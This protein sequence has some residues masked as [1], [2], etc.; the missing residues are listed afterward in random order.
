MQLTRH[1]KIHG[2]VQDVYFRDFT[3]QQAKL[4]RLVGWVRNCRDG[5]VESIATGS[6]EAHQ[7]FILKLQQGPTRARVEW[8]DT[9]NIAPQAFTEF[10]IAASI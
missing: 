3:Q 1:Y 5:T 8:V 9:E 7:A 2:K 4:L 6:E 10:I